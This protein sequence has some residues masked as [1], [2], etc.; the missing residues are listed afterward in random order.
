MVS[1]IKH[2]LLGTF[3]Q[4]RKLKMRFRPSLDPVPAMV[5][6]LATSDLAPA[7]PVDYGIRE[8]VS[9][10][11][12]T[13]ST[14]ESGQKIG[15]AD[16]KTAIIAADQNYLSGSA[17]ISG[18]ICFV[19]DINMHRISLLDHKVSLSPNSQHHNPPAIMPINGMKALPVA[20]GK[21]RQIE[22]QSLP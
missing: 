10:E 19:Y 8:S 3:A 1:I 2:R 5:Q 20:P 6:A 9:D 18:V 7:K 15:Q 21:I 12:I 11:P 17:I 16:M 13:A 22:I 4:N 14:I